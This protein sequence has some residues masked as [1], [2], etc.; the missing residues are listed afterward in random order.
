M[1]KSAPTPD[2]ETFELIGGLDDRWVV[3]RS[4][5]GLVLL[6]IRAASERILFEKLRREMESGTVAVQQLLLPEVIEL[7]VKDSVWI[8]ENLPPLHA[9]GFGIEA[10]GGNAFKLEAL[11]AALAGR[12]AR[13]ALLDIC[14]SLRASGSLGNRSVA[15]ESLARSVSSLA[16]MDG[17]SYEENRA[18]KLVQELL[19]CE[20]PYASPRGRPT[21]IQ[22]S[23]SELDR[24]FS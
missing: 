22:W 8:S 23:F 21:M 14:E 15:T 24:K 7:P 13:G 20:L 18:R 9:A 6:H 4:K 5:D 10:F 19:R 16:A 11:P 3:M 12:D 2:E 1:E 17:F